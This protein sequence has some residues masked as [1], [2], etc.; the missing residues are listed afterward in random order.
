MGKLFRE[1]AL[2]GAGRLATRK[3]LTDNDFMLTTLP[4]HEHH[5]LQYFAANDIKHNMTIV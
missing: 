1:A 4:D 3:R 5:V 2:L